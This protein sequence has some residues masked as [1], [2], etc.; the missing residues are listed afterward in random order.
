MLFPLNYL[1]YGFTLAIAYPD[2][3]Y[4]ITYNKYLKI[5]KR[6]RPR[7]VYSE[8]SK[9]GIYVWSRRLGSLK[10]RALYNLT[11]SS[12]ND[13]IRTNSYPLED[14]GIAYLKGNRES[15]EAKL[16]SPYITLL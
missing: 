10:G 3:L 14:G 4:Y 6:Y 11:E 9:L 13:S 12:L 8:Y 1:A 16:R 7:Y 2:T 5:E 15:K